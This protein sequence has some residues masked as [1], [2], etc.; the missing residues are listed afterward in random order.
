M[1]TDHPASER[2][3]APDVPEYERYPRTKEELNANYEGDWTTLQYKRFSDPV[4]KEK[5][6]AFKRN[7]P[8]LETRPL[9]YFA[10]ARGRMSLEKPIDIPIDEYEEMIDAEKYDEN[11]VRL[12]SQTGYEDSFY[13][14]KQPHSLGV[15]VGYG[16]PGAVFKN[17]RD[18]SGREVSSRVKNIVEAHEKSHGMFMGLTKGE[19]GYI[20][21]IFATEKNSKKGKILDEYPNKSQIDEVI[22]RMSQLKN[23]FGFDSHQVFTRAHLDV[24]REHYC[25]DTDSDN[26]MTEFLDAIDR[27][28]EDRFVDLMNTIA[29]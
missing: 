11:L 1:Y 13:Y 6:L 2:A 28:N 14:N 24:A 5:Y 18:S 10:E 3:D 15:S 29:C 8:T 7:F 27:E 21:D 26:D 12:F 17:A 25:K 16:D 23:Y 19:K 20:R 9:S 4:I 22:A